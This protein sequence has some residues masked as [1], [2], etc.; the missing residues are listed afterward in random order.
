M[1]V[2]NPDECIN[3]GACEPECPVDAILPDSRPEADK[4][5]DL[6]AQHALRWPGISRKGPAPQDAEA[7]RDKSGK[8]DLWFSGA[9]ATRA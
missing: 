8:F 3:C 7:W 2:I 4:W 5:L 6:N 1:L 9:P